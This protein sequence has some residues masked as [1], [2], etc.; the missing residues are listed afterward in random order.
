MTGHVDLKPSS[1][2]FSSGN[3]PCH[4]FDLR[5]KR[6]RKKMFGKSNEILEQI[7]VDFS[8]THQCLSFAINLLP[9]GKSLRF[10]PPRQAASHSTSVGNR[11]FFHLQY[12]LA[13]N[14]ET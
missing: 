4:M 14:H 1:A 8:I 12:A 7:Y 3:W 13:S 9:Q 6:K 11:L 2:K 5:T 10:L